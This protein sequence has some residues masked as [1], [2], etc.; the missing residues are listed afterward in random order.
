MPVN[1]P[2]IALYEVFPSLVPEFNEVMSAV[3]SIITVDLTSACAGAI[4]P[5]EKLAAVNA[6]ATKTRNER[7]AF[8]SI[9]PC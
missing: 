9:S 3:E 7:F 4:A 1:E 2:D 8:M 6:T 5:T